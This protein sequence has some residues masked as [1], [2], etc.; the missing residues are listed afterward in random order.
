MSSVHAL[1]SRCTHCPEAGRTVT[2]TQRRKPVPDAGTP[3]P[4][5]R[6]PQA[7]SQK[8]RGT[9]L[10]A[11]AG[12]PTHGNH[13]RPEEPGDLGPQDLLL[14]SSPPSRARGQPDPGA[15]TS[16]PLPRWGTG[17]ASSSHGQDGSLAPRKAGPHSEMLK[18]QVEGSAPGAF[19][20]LLGCQPD[21]LLRLGDGLRPLMPKTSPWSQPAVPRTRA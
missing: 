9:G 13:S 2:P 11:G 20:R 3:H 16:V 19:L 15:S 18:P 14:V 8:S 12:V 4:S 5:L 1:P 10:R 6:Q 17:P 7:P 21:A